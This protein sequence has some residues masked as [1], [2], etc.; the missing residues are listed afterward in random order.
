[1]NWLRRLVSAVVVCVFLVG[2]TAC[3]LQSPAPAQEPL[4]IALLEREQRSDDGLPP[5]L[6]GQL[7]PAS[8][9]LIDKRNSRTYWAARN[10]TGEICLIVGFNIGRP[11]FISGIGCAPDEVVQQ[12]GMTVAIRSGT[13]FTS[14]IFVPDGY[15]HSLVET[16]PG[17]FVATNLVGFDSRESMASAIGDQQQVVVPS[18]DSLLP[19][20]T[21]QILR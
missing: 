12:E 6:V 10:R 8:V 9:R 7:D 13:H 1:M 14:A 2:L 4:V 17:N 3:S 11:D 16:F 5:E 15:T 18:D 19:S 21:V 20:L